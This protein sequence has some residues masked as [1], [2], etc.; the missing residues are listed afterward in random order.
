MID[1][2]VVE[3]LAT[4]RAA[5]F[6]REEGMRVLAPLGTLCI[7]SEGKW[8]VTA[9]PM[10]KEMDGWTHPSYDPDVAGGKLYLTLENGS[11][12]CL[13]AGE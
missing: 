4:A 5:G 2:L 7:R 1:L 8:N 3:D 6:T 11:A 13:G 10:P 9:K 12:L